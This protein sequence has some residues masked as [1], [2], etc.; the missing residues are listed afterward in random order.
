MKIRIPV[1]AR[2]YHSHPL[3]SYKERRITLNV[4]QNIVKIFHLGKTYAGGNGPKWN[5]GN[6]TGITNCNDSDII[7]K[8][9]I[10]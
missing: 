2:P 9:I 3:W 8:L 6:Q 10:K 7:L 1:F 5:M 4:N